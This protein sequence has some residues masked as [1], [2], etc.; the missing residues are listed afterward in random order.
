MYQ[1]APHQE[2]RLEILWAFIDAHP[3]GVLVTKGNEG[4]CANF[5]PVLLDKSSGS[6]GVLQAHCARANP[7]WRDFDPAI[8]ALVIFQGP[9]AYVTPSWYPSKVV[10]GKVVPTWNYVTVH[11]CGKMTAIDDT[12]WL[13]RQIEQMTEKMEANRANPWSVAHAPHSFIEDMINNIIG[14]EIEISRLEGKWKL[15]QNRSRGD[16]NGVI[17]ELR[18]SG[19]EPH[20][21]MAK[22]MSE[23]DPAK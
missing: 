1:P 14:L 9:Q 18:A 7:Q 15:S 17:E 2:D 22:L 3:L 11:A 23:F 10:H 20:H 13:R 19:E 8:E 16:R 4:L 21:A 5:L 12:A 6:K